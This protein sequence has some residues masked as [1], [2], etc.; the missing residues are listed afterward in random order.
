MRACLDAL[1][2]AALRHVLGLGSF[3]LAHVA[4]GPAWG[5]DAPV[6][7]LALVSAVALTVGLLLRRWLTRWG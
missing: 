1:T 7:A 5:T 6:V 3:A 2:H 4:L